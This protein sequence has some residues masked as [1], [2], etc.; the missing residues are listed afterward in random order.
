MCFNP[1]FGT[2]QAHFFTAVPVELQ[3]S[4]WWVC[5]KVTEN[6]HIDYTASAIVVNTCREFNRVK[7]CTERYNFICF[8]SARNCCAYVVACSCYKLTFNCQS[9]FACT[10]FYHFKSIFDSDACCWQIAECTQSISC[11]TLQQVAVFI[12][13]QH[14]ASHGDKANSAGFQNFSEQVQSYNAV[15]Q[16]NFAFGVGN[17]NICHVFSIV[18]WCFDAFCR[19]IFAESVCSYN[20]FFVVRF[21]NFKFSHF[22]YIVFNF[23]WFNVSFN[24][25][26]FNF[27]LQ[28]FCG[29]QF[30]GTAANANKTDFF[31]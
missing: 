3:C 1:S 21:Q 12:C 8:V 17:I 2:Q 20:I 13:V 16:D 19:C 5:N 15:N 27:S 7:V 29:F 26:C 11:G 30:F 31:K 22:L 14:C 18:E 28:H 6:F 9:N 24:A 25:H 23:E 4:S 10:F